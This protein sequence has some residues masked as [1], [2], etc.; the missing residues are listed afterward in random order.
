V[1]RKRVL[2]GFSI[3]AGGVCASLPFLRET[4]LTLPL[5][6][7]VTPALP[8]PIIH[9]VQPAAA[10][11]SETVA[12]ESP[13]AEVSTGPSPYIDDGSQRME[14]GNSDA[15]ASSMPPEEIT[16][17][18]KEKS[19]SL[20]LLPVSFQ[21]KQ[22]E[23]FHTAPW[24]PARL[25]EGPTGPPREYKIRKTDTL[26]DLALRFLG[27]QDKADEL[28]E[29]NRSVLNDRNILPLG[30]VIRIPAGGIDTPAENSETD[31]QP[32]GQPGD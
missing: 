28:F 17:N 22:P 25:A 5:Q 32:V 18:P 10:P 15:I 23:D 30:V 21:V 4:P 2:L 19:A 14:R 26:E 24:Q 27:S 31:L 9:L 16:A 1:S 12:A 8:D 13:S 3:I 6:D 7:S 29:A 20:P 11:P